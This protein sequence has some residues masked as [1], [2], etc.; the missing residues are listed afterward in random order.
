MQAILDM[1]IIRENEIVGVYGLIY[2]LLISF[3]RGDFA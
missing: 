2:A 1:K 3:Y